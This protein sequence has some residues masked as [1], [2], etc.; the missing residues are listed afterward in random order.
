MQVAR[1]DLILYV[2]SVVQFIAICFLLVN[3]IEFDQRF[4]TANGR[5]T[6]I[7]ATA[8]LLWILYLRRHQFV[9]ISQVQI[10]GFAFLW[11]VFISVLFSDGSQYY[12]TLVTMI[13]ILFAITPSGSCDTKFI[14]IYLLSLFALTTLSVCFVLY[15]TVSFEI[16]RSDNSFYGY[17]GRSVEIS[18]SLATFLPRSSGFSRSSVIT[19]AFFMMIYLFMTQLGSLSKNR[20]L[21]YFIAVIR[22][23]L[24]LAIASLASMIILA[25]SRGTL[26]SILFGAFMTLICFWSTPSSVQRSK[27]ICLSYLIVLALV[28]SMTQFL[29]LISDLVS[30]FGL[31]F[32]RRF[33]GRERFWMDIVNILPIFP[34]GFGFNGD[35]HFFEFSNGFSASGLYA[36]TA[37]NGLFFLLISFGYLAIPIFMIILSVVANRIEILIKVLDYAADKRL[38][39]GYAIL[40]FLVCFILARSIFET[41]FFVAGIDLLTLGVLF[42]VT[43]CLRLRSG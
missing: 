31:D 14:F 38:K 33:S 4:L 8:L 23:G 22:M 2:Q 21:S 37:S 18:S 7:F 29:S 40:I 42:R 30:F 36:T 10:V 13:C 6:A 15:Q 28:L 43:E 12:W 25:G 19:A 5:A 3:P 24:V 20:F 11:S 39:I 41:G 17:Y 32:D 26:L 27:F 35:R 16:F 34:F 9:C 1:A